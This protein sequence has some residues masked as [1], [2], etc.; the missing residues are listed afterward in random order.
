MK[1]GV[2]IKIGS[3]VTLRTFGFLSVGAETVLIMISSLA[4]T[5]IFQG[6]NSVTED[7]SR[8][9]PIWFCKVRSDIEAKY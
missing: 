4:F 5:S 9:M 6:L 8:A 1:Y 7:F 3:K 2:K